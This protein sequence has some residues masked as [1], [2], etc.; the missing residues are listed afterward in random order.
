MRLAFWRRHNGDASGLLA[1]LAGYRPPPGYDR[2]L[3]Q[4]NDFRAVFLQ[5]EQGKRVL[6]SI[7]RW[8]RVYQTVFVRGDR[9]ATFVNEGARNLG[10]KLLMTIYEEP[11]PRPERAPHERKTT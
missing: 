1:E 3:N 8:A 5:T 4:H 10:L 6:W 7:L 2:S 9:D 11:Q